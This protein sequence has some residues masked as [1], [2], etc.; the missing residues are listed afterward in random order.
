[1]KAEQPLILRKATMDDAELLLEW[2]NETQSRKNS[3]HSEVIDFD[4]HIDWLKRTLKND[5]I[6]IYIVMQADKAVGDLRLE[7]CDKTVEFSWSVDYRH[8]GQGLGKRI[9][10]KAIE[11]AGPDIEK[12][13]RIKADNI[14]SIKNAMSAGFKLIREEN[15][16][17]KIFSRDKPCI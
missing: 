4:H 7:Y 11:A 15:P 14:A 12:I 6:Q 1:M 17:I 2:R 13:C 16:N 8:R 3:I 5:S 9:L 10:A